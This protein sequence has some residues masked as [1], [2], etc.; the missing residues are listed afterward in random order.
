M[1]KNEE[2]IKINEINDY[3][4]KRISK[5]V[6]YINTVRSESVIGKKVSEETEKVIAY[7]QK[8]ENLD[9]MYVEI[10]EHT[11]RIRKQQRENTERRQRNARNDFEDLGIG[12]ELY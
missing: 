10:E 7:M 1:I 5:F 8:Q 3:K 9:K 11:K 6:N 4:F 12:Q 2:N